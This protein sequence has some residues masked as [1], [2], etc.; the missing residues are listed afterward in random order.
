[1][2]WLIV[3]VPLVLLGLHL[4][5]SASGEEGPPRDG[6]SSREI[7][8]EIE[9]LKAKGYERAMEFHGRIAPVMKD[10]LWGFIDHEYR[11]VQRPFLVEVD[12][13][14]EGYWA[15]KNR[16]GTWVYVNEEGK[17][18]GP[19]KCSRLMPVEDGLGTMW[20]EDSVGRDVYQK[21]R[22]DSGQ[23]EGKAPRL[24]KY[25][26]SRQTSEFG[27]CRR[28]ADG[29]WEIQ[30]PLYGY[31]LICEQQ[32]GVTQYL[33]WE[34]VSILHGRMLVLKDRKWFELSRGM[35]ANGYRITF[36]YKE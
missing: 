35:K 3:I 19:Y 5:G 15:G 21:I 6:R 26:E 4:I 24:D 9:A 1:M 28:S 32:G 20:M 14:S 7:R 33:R 36:L 22:P 27:A 30:N 34:D 31:E 25:S 17:I 11:W 13:W 8:E 23:V 29:L 18:F 10:G 2:G 16:L 12:R